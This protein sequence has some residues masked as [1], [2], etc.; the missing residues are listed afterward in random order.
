MNNVKS[1]VISL[2]TPVAP[3]RAGVPGWA[4]EQHHAELTG[5]SSFHPCGLSA[6]RLVAVFVQLVPQRS[7]AD[8]E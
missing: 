3:R 7:D 6:E 4:R 5:L 1:F 2:L 8:L